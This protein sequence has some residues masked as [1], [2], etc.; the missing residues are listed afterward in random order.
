MK[1]LI[2]GTEAA[3]DRIDPLFR[4]AGAE[5]IRVSEPGRIGRVSGKPGMFTGRID[6]EAFQAH[7]IVLL[8]DTRVDPLL[9]DESAF[10]E[11]LSRLPFGEP[12]AVVMDGGER[13]FSS[14]SALVL[15]RAILAVKRKREV[16]VFAKDVRTAD[17]EVELLYREARQAGVG[18]VKYGAISIERGGEKAVVRAFG[19]DS[20]AASGA[21]EDGE[22][23]VVRA[24]WVLDVSRPSAG[25]IEGFASA[26]RL[27]EKTGADTMGRFWLYPAFTSRRGVSFIDLSFLADERLEAIARAIVSD[28]LGE[29][30]YAEVDAAKCAF[31]YTCYRACP[32]AA[33]APDDEASAMAVVEEACE[34]CGIC[35]A[36]CP[37]NAI[38]MKG[39]PGKADSAAGAEIAPMKAGADSGRLK[40][41]ACENSAYHA[42]RAVLD[43][44][45]DASGIGLESVPCCG[46]VNG[47]RIARE[48]RCYDAVLVAACVDDACRHFDGNVKGC[49]HAKRLAENMARLGLP[50]RVG[51]C[52]ASASMTGPLRRQ[53][54]AMGGV[55][56]ASGSDVTNS[57]RPNGKETAS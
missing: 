23:V 29:A 37:A 41:L 16:V 45:P 40:I 22:P 7:A 42:A 10:R 17:P 4:S 36:V 47:A 11:R 34:A 57:G 43:G 3:L 6:G 15:R 18:F 56:A 30:G 26:F 27:R 49:A 12:L 1:I 50:G 52:Q 5:T 53:I 13:S 35:V 48:L 25:D 2:A 38:S 14:L 9:A 20:A 8:G 31:C 44:V 54:L 21:A 39:G 33:L 51:Y 32:H 24:G 55:S 46:S 19:A 28:S